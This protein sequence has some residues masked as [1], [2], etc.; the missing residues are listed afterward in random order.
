MSAKRL[1]PSEST[2]EKWVD[3]GLTH[4]EIVDRVF[5]RENIV[6]S[7][8][9]VAAAL[10][11]AGLTNRVRYETHIPWSPIRVDHSRAYPL[12]MLRFLARRDAGLPLTKDQSERLDSWLKRL[13]DEDAV[14]GYVYDDPNGFKYFR[15]KKSDIKY[16]PIRT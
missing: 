13:E 3:E 8:S 16:P 6:V 15:R 10:S 1:L 7:K 14:V 12:S 2:L 5:E 9:A 11:R 4:Q